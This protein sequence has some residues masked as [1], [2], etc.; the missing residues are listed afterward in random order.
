MTRDGRVERRIFGDQRQ[1]EMG[2]L[3]S[4]PVRRQRLRIVGDHVAADCGLLVE[5][6]DSEV[7]GDGEERSRLIVEAVVAEG[8]DAIRRESARRDEHD[9][10]ADEQR[11][12]D[13]NGTLRPPCRLPI[14]RRRHR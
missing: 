2:V 1:L 11:E 6:L 8:V 10:D 4:L 13:L 9:D 12:R 3:P 5:H 7:L 14:L